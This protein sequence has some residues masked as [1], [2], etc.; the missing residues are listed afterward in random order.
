M[1][2]LRII[3]FAE[4]FPSTSETWIHHEIS[5]LQQLGCEIKVFATRP[6]PSDIPPELL[7]FAAITT[8]LPD[9]PRTCRSSVWRI[10]KAALLVPVLGGLVFDTKGLR[11]RVQV[12]RDLVY[13]GHILPRAVDFAPR[14]LFAHF[15][16]TRTN[17]ALFCSLIMGVPFGFK[18]HAADVFK[19]VA[20]FRLKTASASQ[21]MTI[22]A[23][24]IEFIR[25]H[26][27]DIDVS[28]FNI[29]RCGLPLNEYSFQ[30]PNRVSDIPTI[31]AVGRLVRMK[32]FNILLRASR[33][34]KDREFKHHITIIGDG[35]ERKNLDALVA[36]LDLQ[37]IVTFKGYLG[38]HSVR[39]SLLRSSLFVLPSVWDPLDGTQDGIPVALM[40]AMALGVLVVST[41]T[42][43]IP[44]LIKHG[45]TGF[46]TAPNDHLALAE[47]IQRC[48]SLDTQS[49]ASILLAAREMVEK[50]HDAQRLAI[51]L[52]DRLVSSLLSNA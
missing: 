2:A 14:F 1:G 3:Y 7:N 48:C 4:I 31:V 16:G 39:E 26:Y 18:M 51:I 13:V 17:L 47:Q 35:P 46:L 32:G 30:P 42:S 43:G 5:E 9:L 10:L 22:S 23:Y 50:H 21:V 6:R 19:R 37:G 20:L 36:E 8:Y 34:L 33:V 11:L 38:P 40:E 44:E 52:R 41:A 49:K 45:I 12:I 29:H 27:P 15:A 28:R 25:Q 24:N